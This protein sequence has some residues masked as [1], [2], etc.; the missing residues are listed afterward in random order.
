MEMLLSKVQRRVRATPQ[1]RCVCPQSSRRLQV[2][3]ATPSAPSTPLEN[4]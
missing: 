2:R 4:W 3:G 1:W